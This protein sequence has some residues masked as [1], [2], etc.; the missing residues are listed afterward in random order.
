MTGFVGEEEN[1]GPQYQIYQITKGAT[2][3]KAGRMVNIFFFCQIFV[4]DN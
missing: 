1:D 2:M 4:N 3:L